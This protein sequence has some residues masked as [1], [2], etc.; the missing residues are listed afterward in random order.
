[1]PLRV[2]VGVVF[3][4]GMPLHAMRLDRTASNGVLLGRD[5]FQ[6]CEPGA[7]G[8]P[9]QVVQLQSLGDGSVR[10]LPHDPVNHSMAAFPA[11]PAVA[12]P[13]PGACPNQTGTFLDKATGDPLGETHNDTTALLTFAGML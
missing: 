5:D 11:S 8:V 7:G 1:M 9:T 13:I 6:M 10:L 4:E 2:D 3:I 12:I